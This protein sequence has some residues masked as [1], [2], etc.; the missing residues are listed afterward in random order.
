MFKAGIV[1]ADEGDS[2]APS[3]R[4]FD[5]G[6]VPDHRGGR[7]SRSRRRRRIWLEAPGAWTSSLELFR[8]SACEPD[9][10]RGWILASNESRGVANRESSLSKRRPVPG[11]FRRRAPPKKFPLQLPRK[12]IRSRHH[13]PA[14]PPKPIRARAPIRTSTV[15]TC[16]S[17][18]SEQRRLHPVEGRVPTEELL[19]HVARV[20][21]RGEGFRSA[22]CGYSLAKLTRR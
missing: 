4:R 5:R 15:T 16:G 2:L 18:V 12:V 13:V 3:E 11:S 7:G 14:A 1:D 6:A 17:A 21:W 10:L 19:F 22:A 20:S 9:R 8:A